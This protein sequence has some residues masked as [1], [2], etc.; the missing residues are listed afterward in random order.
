MEICFLHC[1]QSEILYQAVNDE[2]V[3]DQISCEGT[4]VQQQRWVLQEVVR[5]RAGSK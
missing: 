5:I 3:N 1:F 4:K 2:P